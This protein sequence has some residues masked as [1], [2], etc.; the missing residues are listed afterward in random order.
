MGLNK[1]RRKRKNWKIL[2]YGHVFYHVGEQD[3]S[4]GGMGFIIKN[5]VNDITNVKSTSTSV[6]DKK[7]G[8]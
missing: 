1:I 4:V 6:M 8:F 2:K 5:H 7:N 3:K